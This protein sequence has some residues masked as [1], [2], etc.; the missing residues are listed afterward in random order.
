MIR[1]SLCLAT[2]CTVLGCSTPHHL[3]YDH[4][5]AF[6]DTMAIQA[7]RSRP[8]VAQATY[9]LSGAESLA[10]SQNASESLQGSAGENALTINIGDSSID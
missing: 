8:S 5:R 1:F 2:L 6:A 3:Q 4:G 7:D 9:A 10:L